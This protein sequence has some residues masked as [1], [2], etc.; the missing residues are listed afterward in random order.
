MQFIFSTKKTPFLKPGANLIFSPS[1]QN[2]LEWLNKSSPYSSQLLSIYIAWRV[3]PEVKW[4][5]CADCAIHPWHPTSRRCHRWQLP[6]YMTE[7]WAN[8]AAV[9]KWAECCWPQGGKYFITKN[10]ILLLLFFW[11]LLHAWTLNANMKN[12]HQTLSVLFSSS[13]E[14]GLMVIL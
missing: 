9:K 4:R 5:G 1:W 11:C 2:R 13:W 3:K 7:W 6:Y 8:G 12:V 10:M 14:C